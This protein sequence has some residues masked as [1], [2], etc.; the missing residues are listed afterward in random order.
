MVKTIE[1][2]RTN[3]SIFIIKSKI[4]VFI[5][6]CFGVKVV[7]LALNMINYLMERAQKCAANDKKRI[8]S[9]VTITISSASSGNISS[10]TN[11]GTVAKRNE[12]NKSKNKNK[13]KNKNKGAITDKQDSNSRKKRQY[14]L[15]QQME[16]LLT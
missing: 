9:A 14:D 3:E 11:V 4:I 5:F 8:N 2:Q 7:T 13:N 12:S 16:K 15:R 10:S 1:F 6:Y